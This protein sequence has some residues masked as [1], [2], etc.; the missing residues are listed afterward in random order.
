MVE[1]AAV[2]PDLGTAQTLTQPQLVAIAVALGLDPNTLGTLRLDAD[3]VTMT[4]WDEV[5][6]Q[7]TTRRVPVRGADG[8]PI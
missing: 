5:A 1:V 3:A 2:L 4:S 6:G 7:P 8:E